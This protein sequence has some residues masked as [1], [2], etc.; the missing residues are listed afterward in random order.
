MDNLNAPTLIKH[1]N[2]INLER[3]NKKKR[4]RYSKIKV[5]NFAELDSWFQLLPGSKYF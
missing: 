2:Q 4:I 1:E 3:K 5:R